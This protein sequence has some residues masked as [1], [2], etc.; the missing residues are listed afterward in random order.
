MNYIQFT[1]KLK[2]TICESKILDESTF[3]GHSILLS[4]EGI[5]IDFNRTQLSSIEEA[6]EFIA[7]AKFEEE[8]VQDLYEDISDVK[9]ASLIKEHHNISKV[10]NTIIESYINLASSKVF[11]ADPVVTDLRK[12]IS[13]DRL[14]ESKIDYI[15]NDGSIVAISEE[16]QDILNQLLDDKYQLVEYMR[17]N[18]ENF[19]NILRE[20]S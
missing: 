3:M 8:V 2:E 15:L 4:E 14:I 13:V 19:M 5:F 10:T 18:K 20:L 11:A 16:T 9:I 6:K 1:R 7:K 12:N 17:E